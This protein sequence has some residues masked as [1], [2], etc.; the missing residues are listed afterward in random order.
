MQTVA[1][2]AAAAAVAVVLRPGEASPLR[3]DAAAGPEPVS[4][5]HIPSTT[6]ASG[7]ERRPAPAD[8]LRA[9]TS[10]SGTSDTSGV[11]Q[12]G[13]TVHKREALPSP[14]A[15]LVMRLT[16]RSA[17]TH[18]QQKR[19]AS[20]V[21]GASLSI[22]NPIRVLRNRLTL[23]MYRRW[24]NKV[25][26]NSAFLHSMGKRSTREQLE[27]RDRGLSDNRFSEDVK[28]WLLS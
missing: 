27:R 23:Q 18:S 22:N 3:P 17:G 28:Q 20:P 19:E 9:D 10:T 13:S 12:V 5:E 4:I 11:T 8:R 25:M 21:T 1:L 14:S 24:R 7:G 15:A 16:R 2:L 6:T 26:E